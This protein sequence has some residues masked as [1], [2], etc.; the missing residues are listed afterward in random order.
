MDNE[1]AA[2]REETEKTLSRVQ[3]YN[4]ESL[5]RRDDL[6]KYAFS[7]AVEPARRAIDLFRTLPISHLQYFPFQQLEQIKSISNS[8]FK[9]LQ[10]FEEFDVGSAEPNVADAQNDLLIKL[11]SQFQSIFNALA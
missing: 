11:N 7:E 2:L 5:I 10:Q 6:G 3:E 1:E 9:L 4:P 8:F